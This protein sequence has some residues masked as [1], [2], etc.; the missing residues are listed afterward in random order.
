MHDNVTKTGDTDVIA[1]MVIE[2]ICNIHM[3]L[4]WYGFG[5]VALIFQGE[6]WHW[7]WKYLYLKYC[8]NKLNQNSF[9]TP[10]QFL[11]FIYQS[12]IVMISID[13]NL[14]SYKI[15]ITS[16]HI[17]SSHTWIKTDYIIAL[18]MMFVWSKK[19]YPS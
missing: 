12:L 1:H 4:Q 19:G 2:F 7:I 5:S 18:I 8:I 3:P 11:L 10:I 9:L 14:N 16:C 15:C 13:Y 6:V 17:K